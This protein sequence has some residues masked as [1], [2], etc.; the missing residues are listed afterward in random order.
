MRK[1]TNSMFAMDLSLPMSVNSSSNNHQQQQHRYHGSMMRTSRWLC[2]LTTSLAFLIGVGVGVAVPFYVLPSANSSD[3]TVKSVESLAETVESGHAPIAS[4]LVA[5][6]DLMAQNV[7][8]VDQIEW[9]IDNGGAQ[10]STSAIPKHVS[11]SPV[12]MPYLSAAAR[13]REKEND[14]RN[15]LL[16]YKLVDKSDQVDAK[17]VSAAAATTATVAATAAANGRISFVE[18]QKAL[19]DSVQDVDTHSP[20]GGLKSKIETV[21]GK[22]VQGIFWSQA[23]EDLIPAGFNKQQVENW[24]D[25]SRKDHIIRLEEGCGRMQNRMITFENGTRSC[26]RYRQNYD[27]IQG[28][29]F[30]FYL[31]REL[32]IRNLPPSALGLVRPL[33]QQWANVRSQ[34]SLAQWVEDRPVVFTQFLENLEPAYIPTQFR[35][36]NR[37]LHPSDIQ[38]RQL[39]TQSDRDELATLAQWSDLL[40]FDYLTANLDRMV[41]NLY[42][43]QWNPAMMDAPAHNL[44][45][46]TKTGLLVFLDNE[47]GL[48]HGYRLLD[49]YEVYHKSLLDA[50][51]IFRKSTI[52]S[53]RQLQAKRNVGDLLRHSFETRDSSLVDYLPF[54][55]EKSVKTLNHRIDRVLDQ[56]AKCQSLYGL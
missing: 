24:Q 46:N 39:D 10:V 33:D 29:I 41:N 44:A 37:H 17:T 12:S 26:C 16:K 5:S 28:E 6:I 14:R 22:A 49:K 4:H 7:Q 45:R 35:G 3:V 2:L 48:L 54:L 20:A 40:V 13:R 19:L 43:M 8:S 52:E 9:E 42:N 47:S 1:A 36:T 31:S 55:P 50:I 11:A 25:F 53:L 56:V 18:P 21:T 38:M 23:V 51:C 27:Q 15:S 30:S 34:L 32:G